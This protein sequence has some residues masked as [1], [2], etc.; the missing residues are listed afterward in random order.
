MSASFSKYPNKFYSN[1]RGRGRGSYQNNN[2]YSTRKTGSSK[3]NCEIVD[4]R[5]FDNTYSSSCPR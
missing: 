5:S 4:Q 2:V 1:N 3:T